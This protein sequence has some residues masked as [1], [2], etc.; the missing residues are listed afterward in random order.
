M[1]AGLWVPRNSEPKAV[2]DYGFVEFR[3]SDSDRLNMGILITL[4]K[5]QNSIEKSYFRCSIL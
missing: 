2:L 1:G 5:Y 4:P 3:K